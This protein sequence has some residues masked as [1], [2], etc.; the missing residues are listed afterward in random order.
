MPGIRYQQS[1]GMVNL[2]QGIGS[3]A[4]ILKKDG[5]DTFVGWLGFICPRAT[6]VLPGHFAKIVA[7]A[8]TAG[9]VYPGCT[10][11][12]MRRDEFVV[13]W[14]VVYGRTPRWGVYAIIDGNGWPAL[15][16]HSKTYPPKP[17]VQ[18]L[19]FA[20]NANT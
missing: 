20:R 11:T 6:L 9:E 19:K 1:G 14:R 7:C 5:T 15:K 12:W 8:T 4:P 18:L 2:G 13:G 17:Q 16:S 3:V 10:W